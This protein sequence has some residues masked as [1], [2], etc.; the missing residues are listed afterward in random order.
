[1]L[2]PMSKFPEQIQ[3][4]IIQI[5]QFYKKLNS[6]NKRQIIIAASITVMVL[7]V[8]GVTYHQNQAFTIKVDGKAVG[9]VRNKEDFSNILE[10]MERNLHNAYNVEVVIYQ[11]ITFEKTRAKDKDLTD[12]KT[13]QKAVQEMMNF[14]VKAY[15]IK[16]NNEMIAFLANEEEANGVLESLKEGYTVS[17]DG[18]VEKV[19]FEENVM[20]E[21]THTEA[22]NLKSY[23]D[24]LKFIKQGTEEVKTHEIDQGESFWSI[25]KKYNLKVDDLMAANPNVD[26]S[27]L[28]LKQKLNLVVPKPLITIATVEKA[29]LEEK[30]PFEIE[31]EETA[32][33]FKGETQIK[34]Q[35][36]DG[37]REVVVELVKHNGVEVSRN[38]LEEDIL[39]D[40]SKQVVL[41]GT[42]EPPPKVG[43]GVL[44][45]PT[46]GTLTSRFGSRWGRMHTGIDIAAK[47]GTP[48]HAADGGKVVFSGT[49]GNYGKL[50]IIDHGGGMETYYAHNSKNLVS[51]GDKVHKGQK[52]GE[53]GNTGR[54]T[55][56]H[57]HFEVRK[58]GK[59]VNPLSYVK[60]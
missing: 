28:Q 24:T 55:G 39:D 31:F 37:K 6:K 10:R 25:A 20:V 2:I 32:A 5:T 59:P 54:T 60:Y 42:K 8:F 40:P 19:Y 21:E 23:E 29:R 26:P 45:N 17:Q 47:I 27:K 15:G 30:I 11:D 34:V 13:L 9:V 51:K 7:L 22:K 1:M 18:S 43:T 41:K 49:N 53:V 12:T 36:K 4:L 35:G 46:R 16:V 57:V 56:A 44:A 38:V 58:N 14:E 48:I 50:I 3:K 52:I 33:L